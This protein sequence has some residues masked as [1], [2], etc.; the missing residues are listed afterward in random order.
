MSLKPVKILAAL[1]LMAGV[2]TAS[3]ATFVTWTSPTAGSAN[4][5]TVTASYTYV[6]N[7]PSLSS[8]DL[9]GA[10]YSPA[11]GASQQMVDYHAQSGITWSFSSAVTNLDLY[12]KFWRSSTS[13]GPSDSNYVFSTAPTIQS[14]LSG[15]SISGN[16]LTVS[17][18]FSDGILRFSGPLTSLTLSPPASG[19]GSQVYTLAFGGGSASVSDGAPTFALLGAAIGTLGWATRRRRV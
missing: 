3:A 1:A 13:S 12:L 4:G 5:I 19:G 17:S 11:G 9:S 15:A 2:S 10:N 8:F 18:G 14:G 6:G 16:T 7:P